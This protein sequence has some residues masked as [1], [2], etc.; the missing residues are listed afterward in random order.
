[1]IK[2]LDHK[3]IM[4]RPEMMSTPL[5]A[6]ENP[7]KVETPAEQANPAKEVKA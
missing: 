1:M 2:P 4:L 5:Y 6:L 7:P 3:K